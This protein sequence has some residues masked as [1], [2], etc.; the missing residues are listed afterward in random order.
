MISDD[1]I[2][3]NIDDLAADA[4]SVQLENIEYNMLFEIPGNIY[5]DYGS[6][7]IAANTYK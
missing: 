2:N 5:N 7:N 1:I 4:V 3:D 6:G